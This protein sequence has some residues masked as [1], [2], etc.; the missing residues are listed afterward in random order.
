MVSTEHPERGTRLRS[1]ELDLARCSP[2]GSERDF[3]QDI[4][5]AWL[6][7]DLLDLLTTAQR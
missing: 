1:L 6:G 7:L 4:S 2:A 3:D 5:L